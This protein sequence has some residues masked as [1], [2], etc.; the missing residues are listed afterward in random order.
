MEETSLQMNVFQI[1]PYFIIIT[2]SEEKTP[3]HQFS[4]ISVGPY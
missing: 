4:H 3:Q 1:L 2:V